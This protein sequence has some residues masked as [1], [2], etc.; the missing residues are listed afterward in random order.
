MKVKLRLKPIS[1]IKHTKFPL[2]S[3]A[4][5]VALLSGVLCKTVVEEEIQHAMIVDTAKR[6]YRKPVVVEDRRFESVSH[7]SEWYVR[8]FE[9][10]PRDTPRDTARK[11]NAARYRINTWCDRDDVPGYYWAE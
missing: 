6:P 11:I 8:E 5:R 10:H 7:A 1:Q 2:A 4:G 9:A 3:Q